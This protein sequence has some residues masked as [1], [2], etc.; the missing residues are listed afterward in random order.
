MH[1]QGQYARSK[2]D[3]TPGI[4]HHGH[5][6]LAPAPLATLLITCHRFGVFSWKYTAE[7]W[8]L[9]LKITQSMQILGLWV[10]LCTS[11]PALDFMGFAEHWENQQH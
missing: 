6:S 4:P 1:I 7:Y 9:S 8:T 2:V 11:P 3:R 10:R 5:G